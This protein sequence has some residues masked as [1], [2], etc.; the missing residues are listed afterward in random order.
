MA[1]TNSYGG[2]TAGESSNL[3]TDY[4]ACVL[5]E[6]RTA[7][8]TVDLPTEMTVPYWNVLLPSAPGIILS[9]GDMISD[10]LYRSATIVGSE[11]THMGWRINAKMATT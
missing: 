2:Y 11:L 6:T 3:M 4:P 5:G 8:P 1:A 10:D 9:P 7:S